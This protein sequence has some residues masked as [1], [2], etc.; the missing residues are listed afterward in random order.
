MLSIS[1]GFLLIII[2]ILCEFTSMYSNH[3]FFLKVLKKNQNGFQRKKFTTSQ[4]LTIHQILKATLFCRFLRGI[5]FHTKRKD[6]ANT[7]SLWSPQ[8]NC[9]SQ[10]DALQKHKSQGLLTRWRQRL[11]RYCCWSSARRYITT[12]SVYNLPK[13]HS[14][15]V[16]IIKEKGLTLKKASSRLYPVE[17]IMD[18]DYVDGIVLL[19]Y[20]LTKPNSCCIAWSR[21]QVALASTW[22][23]TKWNMF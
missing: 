1:W 3:F 10:N 19:V 22:I 9:C 8:R 14:S 4:I 12:L 15:N 20:T 21:Q 11:L 7:S 13:L 17:T 16:D 18:I 6:G 5:W 23:Q 2:Y